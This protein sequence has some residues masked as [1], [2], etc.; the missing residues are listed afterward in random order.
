MGWQSQGS[1]ITGEAESGP[2]AL[3]SCLT[4][5]G[6]AESGPSLNR[7]GRV[8]PLCP[9]VRPVSILS[10]FKDWPWGWTVALTTVAISCS[11]L[12]YTRISCEH[13]R[14]SWS[15]TDEHTQSDQPHTDSSSS[16]SSPSPLPVLA[17]STPTSYHP[18]ALAPSALSLP[19]LRRWSCGAAAQCCERAL[20]TRAIVC[21]HFPRPLDAHPSTLSTCSRE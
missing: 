14:L 15:S 13:R 17:I 11:P 6:A 20:T 19:A 4:P 12:F 5:N 3:G 10:G 7:G 2:S 18:R 9:G 21:F 1:L 8:R 16:F